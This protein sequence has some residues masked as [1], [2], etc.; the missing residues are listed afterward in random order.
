M[1]VSFFPV[2]EVSHPAMGLAFSE[3]F[4]AFA[5]PGGKKISGKG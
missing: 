3:R 5:I 1:R 2:I 4:L